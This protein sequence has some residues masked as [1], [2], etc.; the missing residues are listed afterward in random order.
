MT[1]RETIITALID[2]AIEYPESWE[3]IQIAKQSDDELINRLIELVEYY[4]KEIE[5]I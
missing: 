3:L 4:K 5:N 2:N 1:I